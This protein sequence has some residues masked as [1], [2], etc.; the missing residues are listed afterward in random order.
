M[1]ENIEKYSQEVSPIFTFQ[2][3]SRDIF[4]SKFRPKS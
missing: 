2:S 1:T 3:S 4:K